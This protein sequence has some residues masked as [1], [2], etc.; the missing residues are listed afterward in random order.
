MSLW[1]IVTYNVNTSTIEVLKN[2]MDKITLQKHITSAILDLGYKTRR[3]LLQ[4]MVPG[5][6]A[7]KM[8]FQSDDI[9]PGTLPMREK[10]AGILKDGIHHY[11]EH[12][13]EKHYL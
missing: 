11:E 9:S 1:T 13:L 10:Y 2:L 5:Q 8:I 6:S 7:Y 4:H 12:L 3:N